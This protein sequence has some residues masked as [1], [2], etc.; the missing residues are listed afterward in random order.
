MT[1]VAAVQIGLW[2]AIYRKV[3]IE[4]DCAFKNAELM[5]R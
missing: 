4:Y 5:W 1:G 3:R 2:L